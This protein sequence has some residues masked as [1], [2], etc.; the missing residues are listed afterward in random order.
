MGP[1]RDVLTGLLAAAP[2]ALL[3]VDADGCIAF[4]S[5]QAERLFEWSRA[6][7]IGRQVECLIPER[8]GLQHPKLRQTYI[9]HPLTRPMG[10]G[11]DLRGRRRDGSE[12]PVEVNLSAFST[13][14]GSMV[15]VAVHDVTTS[16]RNEQRLRAVLASAPDATVG[17]DVSGRI[18]FVNGQAEIMFG[19][20]ADDLIGQQVEVLVP[21]AMVYTHIFQRDRFST[22]RASRPKDSGLQLSGKRRNGST[23]PAEISLSVVEEADQ[24]LILAAVR[25]VTQRVEDEKENRRAAL[26]AQRAQSHRLESLGQLAGGVA[27]DFNNLL[28]VILN[29]STLLAR[30][31]NNENAIADVGEITAAAERGAALTRQ[32]LAFARRDVAYREP[33][34]IN[35]VV[36]GFVS[37]LERTLG[38]EIELRLD[39]ASQPL[40]VLADRH[41]LEQVL[42]NL[43]L[44]SRDAMESGGVL[45]IATKLVAADPTKRRRETDSTADAVVLEVVD[46]GVGMEPDVLARALEPFFTTKPPGEGTGLGLSTVY[47]IVMQNG[48]R[49]KIDSSPGA[50]TTMTVQFDRID[51]DAVRRER[52]EVLLG[53]HERLLL[54]E[55]EASLRFVTERILS[56]HGYEVFVA[57]DGVHALEVFDRLGGAVD[58][59]VSDVV[60]PRMRGDELAQ[61]LIER[62]PSMRLLLMSG[63]VWNDVDLPG[64]LLE[65]PVSEADLLRAIRE[66]LDA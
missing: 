27:H 41:Q 33:S 21:D 51:G 8:L 3:A 26:E 13:G 39:L 18:E 35:D 59:V 61:R 17:V 23:F 5:D 57:S 54:V 56:E 60:M 52:P 12:F 11:F 44:N 65:K 34:D 47:G 43:S 14:H 6:D 7:L 29:Y 10:V 22:E 31:L 15:A 42:L 36:T 40:V 9:E 4:V 49:I 2:D 66:V 38:D 24:V 58:L 62:Q 28:G 64:R 1:S 30:Q 63:Y 19:W 25:D 55:D 48:G 20:A 50:G 32:L 46:T 45:T 37:L 53:G 16:R